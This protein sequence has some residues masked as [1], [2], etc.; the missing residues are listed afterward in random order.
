MNKREEFELISIGADLFPVLIFLALAFIPKI[1][2]HKLRVI[3][4]VLISWIFIVL[5]TIYIYNP[6]GIAAGHELG[7]HFPEAKYDNNTISVALIG[8]W[9]YPSILAFVYLLVLRLWK[10]LRKV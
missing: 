1:I 9:I 8:G 4:G 5:Y 7:V 2:S 6:A 3:S 10:K